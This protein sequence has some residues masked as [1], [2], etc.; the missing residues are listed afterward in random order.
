MAPDGQLSLAHVVV[1]A[2]DCPRMDMM[3][4]RVLVRVR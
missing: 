1:D 3:E 4:R 2:G